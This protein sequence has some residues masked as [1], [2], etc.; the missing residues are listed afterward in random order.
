MLF[1][2]SGTVAF[3]VL[4]KRTGS[5]LVHHHVFT[6]PTPAA[7]CGQGDQPLMV[8]LPLEYQRRHPRSMWC[9]AGVWYKP[10]CCG[11]ADVLIMMMLLLW[12]RRC[13]YCDDDT[14][15]QVVV[16]L[17]YR[18]CYFLRPVLLWSRGVLLWLWWC[19]CD[20]EQDVSGAVCV[21]RLACVCRRW[22]FSD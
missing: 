13:C 5:H 1:A 9:C 11:T 17:Q 14:L 2:C 7:C 22:R 10:C 6:S 12:Y 21:E 18:Q 15:V 8:Y 3:I 4:H 20:T 19:C 16:L